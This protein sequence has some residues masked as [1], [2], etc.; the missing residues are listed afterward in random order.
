M[1]RLVPVEAAEVG[2]GQFGVR[3]LPAARIGA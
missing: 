1:Q 3:H 2:L